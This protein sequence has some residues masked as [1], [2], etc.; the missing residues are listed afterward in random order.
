MKETAISRAVLPIPCFA[1]PPL[2]MTLLERV[3]AFAR[4]PRLHLPVLGV[5]SCVSFGL[6]L[7]VAIALFPQ[8][9]EIEARRVEAELRAK[10]ASEDQVLIYNKGL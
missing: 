4:R 8:F 5:V 10:L 6:G 9:A 3:P 7:P 1:L 2:V